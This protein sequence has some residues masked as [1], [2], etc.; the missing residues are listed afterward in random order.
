VWDLPI[1]PDVDYHPEKERK[2][3]APNFT[4]MWLDH[5]SNL[6]NVK[7]PLGSSLES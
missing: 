4:G 2:A 3:Q 7:N 6:G 5:F 1:N